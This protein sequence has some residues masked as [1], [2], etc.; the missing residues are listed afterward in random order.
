[1]APRL[2]LCLR[3]RICFDCPFACDYINIGLSAVELLKM[4]FI[5]IIII[6]IIWG[7]R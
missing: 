1:M 2:C 3:V 5:I 6:I 4:K 7:M